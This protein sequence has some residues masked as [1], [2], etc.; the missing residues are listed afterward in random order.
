MLLYDRFDVYKCEIIDVLLY[1]LLVS[2][3]S[4]LVIVMASFFI[5]H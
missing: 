5:L 4:A 1:I 3:L 2:I